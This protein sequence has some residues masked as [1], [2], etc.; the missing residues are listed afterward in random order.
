MSATIIAAW[1]FAY[2]GLYK[3]IHGYLCSAY[4]YEGRPVYF[5]IYRPMDEKSEYTLQQI[6]EILYDLSRHAELPFLQVKFIEERFLKEYQDIAG[7]EIKTECLEDN[8]EYAYKIQDLLEISGTVNFYKRK[9]LKKCFNN[10]HLSIRP[11]TNG[12]IHIC[13]EIENEWC[14]Q[15]DC[16]YCESFAGCEKKAMEIMA[17]IFDENIYTG[18]FLYYDETPV[19]YVICE[20][21]NETL[22]FLYFGKATMH[23]YFIYLI[24]MIFKDYLSDVK[25]MNMNQ[26]MGHTGLRLFKRHLSAHEL[27]RNYTCTFNKPEVIRRE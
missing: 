18:I 16:P 20:K 15:K 7:Y 12:T 23:D 13:A 3:I 5:T 2:H 26:D 25:Y 4:F 22:S 27:W 8:D 19:G 1:S 10:P 21:I 6:I 24:Y 11:I 17:D 14:K 9:R